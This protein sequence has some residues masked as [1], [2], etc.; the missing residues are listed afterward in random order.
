MVNAA[1]YAYQ[2]DPLGD[3]LTGQGANCKA[4]CQSQGLHVLSIYQEKSTKKRTPA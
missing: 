1:I 3:R 2:A 4:Y